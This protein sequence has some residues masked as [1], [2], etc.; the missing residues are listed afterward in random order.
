MV[1]KRAQVENVL[2]N[3]SGLAAQDTVLWKVTDIQ[4]K[5]FIVP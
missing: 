3:Q 5:C 2:M 4:F 1:R